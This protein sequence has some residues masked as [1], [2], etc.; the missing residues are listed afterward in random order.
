[1]EADGLGAAPARVERARLLLRGDRQEISVEDHV[2]RL[3]V[4]R[5]HLHEDGD[6]A[7]GPLPFPGTDL[8]GNGEPHPGVSDRVDEESRPT[9]AT[10]GQGH[11]RSA[12]RS[13]VDGGRP[14]RPAA[15]VVA[16]IEVSLRELSDAPRHA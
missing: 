6:D 16:S 5:V 4:R 14:I 12:E 11:H 13:V 15:E 10:R 1:P 3:Y 2:A 8:S 7:P 9:G